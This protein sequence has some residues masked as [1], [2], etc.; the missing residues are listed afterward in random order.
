[1]ISEET[2]R[3][4]TL[5][6][7]RDQLKGERSQFMGAVLQEAITR[8]SLSNQHPSKVEQFVVDCEKVWRK[9]R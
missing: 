7:Y 9:K 4:T 6:F 2:Q 8:L 5:S 3:K 1:M